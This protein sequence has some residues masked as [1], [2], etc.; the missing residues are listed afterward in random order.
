MS[1][2][3]QQVQM[4]NGSVQTRS[5]GSTDRNTIKVLIPFDGSE[6]SDVALS[7]LKRAGLPEQLEAFLAVTSVWLPS[8]P[9]E[10]T[11]AV[12]ARR[13]KALTAGVSS[14]APALRN[15]E[16]QRVLS[17]EAEQRIRSDFPPATISTETLQSEAAVS[18]EVIRRAERWGAELI[19]V[20]A[21]TSPS[22]YITDYAGPAL[23]IA[24]EATCSVRI[25]RICAQHEDS[26]TRLIIALETPA[27]SAHLVERVAERH[28]PSETEVHLVLLRKRGPHDQTQDLKENAMLE[29]LAG[30]LRETGLRVFVTTLTG[31]P[32]EILLSK[33]RELAVDCVFIDAAGTNAIEGSLGA[34]AQ[35]LVLGAH[36]SVEVVRS[37]S[38]NPTDFKPAA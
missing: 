25:A 33:A 11:R 32:K 10:I 30:P 13:L 36:C 18:N 17:R 5:D 37:R 35:V 15:Y 8:S 2:Q 3:T 4:L 34:V 26:P 27:S 31:Q 14:F 38:L 1:L 28:W 6:N 23:K 19:I 7:E 20:G 29:Q 9:Y 16:E 12:S 24:R 21:K 22:P